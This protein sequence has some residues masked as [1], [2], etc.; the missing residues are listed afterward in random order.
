MIKKTTKIEVKIKIHIYNL[1]SHK[2]FT[3]CYMKEYTLVSIFNKGNED[4]KVKGQLGIKDFT[5][6]LEKLDLPAKALNQAQAQTTV[7]LDQ[8]GFS[9]LSEE[10]LVQYQNKEVYDRVQ[11]GSK[12][13]VWKSGDFVYHQ[14]RIGQIVYFFEKRRKCCAHLKMY[15]KGKKTVLEETSDPHELFEVREC[16]NVGL[17]DIEVSLLVKF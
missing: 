3:E 13:V 6:K 9:W 8:S 7:Q 1:I 10:P 11:V 16:R 17:S 12:D 2:K 4:G 5:I 15:L 14:G